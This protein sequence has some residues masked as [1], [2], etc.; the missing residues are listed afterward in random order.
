[1]TYTQRLTKTTLWLIGLTYS[2]VFSVAFATGLPD[3]TSLIKAN[4]PT[5][6]Q[7]DAHKSTAARPLGRQVAPEDLLRYFFEGRDIPEVIPQKLPVHS[8]GSGFFIDSAG[9]ILTNAH[10]VKGSYEITVSTTEQ[11]E[12]PAELVGLDERTDVA[13]L[14]VKGKAHPA[15]KIGDS[16]QVEVGNWVFAIG[17]PFGFDYTATKGIVSAVSRSLPDGTYVPFIQTDAAINPGNSG[18][19]LFNLAGEVIGVN[20]QIYSH[21]GAFNGL[22]FAIPIDTAMNVANQLRNKGFVE[23]GWLGIGIQNVTQDLAKSLGLDKPRGALITAI[24]VDSPAAKAGIRVG[25]IITSFDGKAI[26]KWSALPPKVGTVEVGKVVDIELLRAGEPF[27]LKAT[28][29]KLQEGKAPHRKPV[30]DDDNDNYG[31]RVA[32]LSPKQQTVLA[33]NGGVVVIQVQPDSR[34]DDANFRIGDIIVNVDNKS[35]ETVEDFQRAIS[36]IPQDEPIAVLVIRQGRS[37][38]ISF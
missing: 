24:T 1:M 22:A 35:I 27:T 19:P 3:F 18:G 6:V 29:G 10:V 31:L 30:P 12:Y 25:D 16:E 36:Q 26:D 23:R 21:T 14:K 34:A 7:V 4:A 32:N 8:H 37:L 15:A 13:L 38:F 20:S 17:S 9:Y 2:A 5:V 11:I 33:I 28:V